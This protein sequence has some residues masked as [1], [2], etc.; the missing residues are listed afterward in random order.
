MALRARILSSN[1][2]P[3]NILLV[4][5]PKPSIA[6][7]KRLLSKIDNIILQDCLVVVRTQMLNNVTK[8]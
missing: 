2:V 4:F 7:E 1:Y 8:K 3:S 5:V 6:R